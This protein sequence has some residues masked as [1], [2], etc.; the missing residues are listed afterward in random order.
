M[1]LNKNLLKGLAIGII[2]I[3]L[4]GAYASHKEQQKEAYE[5]AQAE[6]YKMEIESLSLGDA[7]KFL[8]YEDAKERLK[9]E[10]WEFYGNYSHNENLESGLNNY[11]WTK[12]EDGL[13]LSYKSPSYGGVKMIDNIM[14]TDAR[15]VQEDFVK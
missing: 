14:F 2:V 8:N 4:G 7:L 6:Q 10:G 13:I 9:S 11:G 3:G 5:K 15:E 12:G 1:K